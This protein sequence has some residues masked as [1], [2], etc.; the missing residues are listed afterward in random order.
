VRQERFYLVTQA[1]LCSASAAPHAYRVEP[2]RAT[3]A[4]AVSLRDAF[5]RDFGLPDDMVRLVRRLD[6]HEARTAH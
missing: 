3:D 2:P 5:Q 6:A 1:T 4:I